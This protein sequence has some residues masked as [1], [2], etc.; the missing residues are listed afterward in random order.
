[1]LQTMPLTGATTN[2]A[3]PEKPANGRNQVRFVDVFVDVF[4]A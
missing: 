3:R 4:C 1:M 2:S